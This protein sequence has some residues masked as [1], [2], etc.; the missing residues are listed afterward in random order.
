MVEVTFTPC[1]ED[2]VAVQRTMF[3]RSLRSRKFIGRTAGL[4]AF[5]GVGAMAIPFLVDGTASSA[6]LPVPVAAMGALAIIIGGNWLLLPR[7]ARRLFMQ[8]KTLHH[9]HRT[10]FDASGFRQASVRAE[11]ALPWGELL[12]WHLGRD[13]L[14]LY[15]ND[16]LAYF[17]PVR[18][19]GP[20]QLAQVEAVL[21]QA[22][23]PRR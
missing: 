12:G 23:L 15:S 21:M 2:Y 10:M 22:N 6:L 3:A 14:L 9:E 19:F 20:E 8:Q 17:I 13:V 1:P 16:H 11:I 4:L 5:I 7:R 18:A